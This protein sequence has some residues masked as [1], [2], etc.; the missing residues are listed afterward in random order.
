MAPLSAT[1]IGR[2]FTVGAQS[3]N[4]ALKWPATAFYTLLSLV[5]R[6][7]LPMWLRCSLSLMYTGWALSSDWDL[8]LESL[9]F[10]AGQ[11]DKSVEQSICE[12]HSPCLYFLF[13]ITVLLLYIY[14]PHFSSNLQ[15]PSLL[16][17]LYYLPFYTLTILGNFALYKRPF[18]PTELESNMPRT[19]LFF[20]LFFLLCTILTP[21]KSIASPDLSLV[22]GAFLDPVDGIFKEVNPMLELGSLHLDL[23]VQRILFLLLVADV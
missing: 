4:W 18:F 22:I 6:C 23:L 9:V 7:L 15:I 12:I 14:T 1:N 11:N 19:S 21:H 8:R 10:I 2:M 3:A 13:S 17:V 16:L 20:F 5:S